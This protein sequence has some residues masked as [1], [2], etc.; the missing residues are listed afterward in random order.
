MTGAL[1]RTK[2]RRTKE[3]RRKKRKGERRKEDGRKKER[4]G[5]G[6]RRKNVERIATTLEDRGTT[7]TIDVKQADD[8]ARLGTLFRKSEIAYPAFFRIA[9]R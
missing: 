2:E 4:G 3:K 7:A 9:W 5:D 6:G 8:P 1:R